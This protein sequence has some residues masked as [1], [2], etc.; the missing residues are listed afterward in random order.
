M[1][2]LLYSARQGTRRPGDLCT[3]SNGASSRL[4]Q[5]YPERFCY[6]R[7]HNAACREQSHGENAPYVQGNLR[8]QQFSSTPLQLG[9]EHLQ[10][11]MIEDLE[12]S[13]GLERLGGAVPEKLLYAC[14]RRRGT[15]ALHT[16]EGKR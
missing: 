3:G 11:G 6:A 5:A 15:K 9:H 16:E 7:T 14:L 4:D 1:R 2:K 8:V 13:T 10:Q 12:P